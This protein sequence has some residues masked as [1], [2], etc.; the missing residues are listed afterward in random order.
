MRN[1]ACTHSVKATPCL[2]TS[3]PFSCE[4]TIPHR[5]WYDNRAANGD[6]CSECTSTKFDSGRRLF[7]GH[8][9]R[10]IS[11]CQLRLLSLYSRQH[12]ERLPIDR[13]FQCFEQHWNVHLHSDRL[14]DSDGDWK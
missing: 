11:L 3:P 14:L 1:W 8:Y 6:Q 5:R 13:D 9:R 7:G 2:H 4:N 10:N 12:G